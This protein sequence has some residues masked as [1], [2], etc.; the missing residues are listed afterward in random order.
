MPVD[1]SQIPQDFHKAVEQ[2]QLP[3]DR[4]GPMLDEY[5]SNQLLEEV[6]AGRLPRA[7]ALSAFERIRAGQ[8]AQQVELEQAAYHKGSYVPA[9]E[10]FLGAGTSAA[11]T[12]APTKLFSHLFNPMSWRE[13]AK[14]SLGP[15]S[16]PFS[17]LFEAGSLGAAPLGDPLYQRGERGYFGSLSEAAKSRMDQFERAGKNVRERY[18]VAGVPI[19]ALQNAF[20]PLTGTAFAGKELYKSLSGPTAAELSMQAEQDLAKYLGD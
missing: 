18:G 11:A 9:P 6:N 17:T 14:L 10:S 19:Q 16:L 8:K 2:G 3:A 20:N 7:H 4:I 13:S 12:V 15:A 1:L 5:V